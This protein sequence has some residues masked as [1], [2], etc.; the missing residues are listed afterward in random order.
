MTD[1]ELKK[2]I[3]KAKRFN[4]TVFTILII[5]IL[6][7]TVWGIRYK[8]QHTFST[9]KWIENPHERVNIV[10][11][12]LLKND[13]IGKTK[14]EIIALLGEESGKKISSAKENSFAYYLGD[15]RRLI[16]IDSEW[17]IITFADGFVSDYEI[18]TD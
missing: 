10:D 8:Y 2:E 3:R 5:G 4:Y 1:E 18:T 16:S 12:M 17:L 6:L 7:C 14:Q 15:E 9:S 13:L 11:D